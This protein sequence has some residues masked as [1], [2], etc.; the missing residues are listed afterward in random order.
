[1]MLFA[2]IVY[3]G[4]YTDEARPNGLKALSLDEATGRME[5]VAEYPVSN[6]LYQALSPDGK[7]LYSCS[8][9]GLAAFDV[10]REPRE[11]FLACRTGESGEFPSCLSCTSCLKLSAAL[12]EPLALDL[13]HIVAMPDGKRV[14]FADYRNGFAGSVAVEGGRFGEA[15]IHRHSGSGPNLPR[16]DKA[17][18]HQALPLPDGSGYAVCDL[19]LDEIV[20]YPSG[21]VFK[22]TPA[23]AGPRHLLFHPNGRLAFLV[24]ELGNFVS[25]LAW[26]PADGFRTLDTLS[27]L[28]NP[29]NLVNPV[30]NSTG[31]N[32]A[33]A[34]RFTPDMKRIVVSNRGENSLVVFDFDEATGH[35]AFKARTLLTGDW[36]RD[37][38]F[39]SPTLAL[40]AMERSGEVHTLRFDAASGGFSILSTLSDLF[41]PVAL[42]CGPNREVE[43]GPLRYDDS[44][45]LKKVSLK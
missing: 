5:V 10:S 39:V 9:E 3:L 27:T 15:I 7:W 42:L 12:R 29:V 37:F 6:A 18:C 14:V 26:S 1:M 19:G 4:C 36:P 43:A 33:A 8:G 17:H 38:I 2:M 21:R 30:Q 44:L 28:E 13:C 34:I 24:S 40:V 23:G 31:A 20:E 41:R 22:T 32:L 25:S 35:L 45:E 16:Q 11:G